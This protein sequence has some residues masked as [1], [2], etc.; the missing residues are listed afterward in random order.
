LFTSSSPQPSP[1]PLLVDGDRVAVQIAPH[2]QGQDF[3]MADFFTV[4]SEGRIA[5]M[6]AYQ[7]A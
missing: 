7:A 3:R 5:R 1:G 2:N 6:V 4:T